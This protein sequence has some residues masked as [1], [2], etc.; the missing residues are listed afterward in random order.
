MSDRSPTRA[1]VLGHA[2]D[3]FSAGL[4]VCRPGQIQS[5]DSS[6]G[7]MDVKP[8]LK[9]FS[10]D[11]SGDTVVEPLPVVPGCV[12]FF[13]QGGDFVD[14]FP[15]QKGDACWL[16]FTDRSLNRWQ[17][18]NGDTDPLFVNRHDLSGA[19]VLVG[20]RPKAQAI[21]EFDTA[22][23]VIGKQGGPRIAWSGTAIHLG[24][25]HN[26]DATEAVMLGTKYTNDEQ[27]TFTNIA[28]KLTAAQVALTLA[29]STLTSA[30]A[31]NA[32]PM[33][34]GATAAPQFVAAAVAIGQAATQIGQAA[35]EF[36]TFAG[37]QSTR[38]STKVKVK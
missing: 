17:A 3:L 15:V 24:V 19:V 14:T 35:T 16:I 36:T 27:N 4:F 7:L 18:G 10:E 2:F 5:V 28:T 8:L 22:R 30:A 9:E 6:T 12:L 13:P 38:L 1:E 29:Q 33:Y 25:G 34:G 20:G 37:Q 21:S 11:A 23:R 31:S 32:V 26:E